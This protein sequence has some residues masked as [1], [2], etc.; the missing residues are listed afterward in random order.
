MHQTFEKSSL[1][2]T[3]KIDDMIELPKSQS[4]RTYKEDLECEMVMVK[5]PKCMSWLDDE[6][7]GDLDMIEDEAENPSPQSSP[8][9]LLSFKECTPPV[10]Y[11]EEA[12][13]T[14]GIPIEIEPLDHTKL[15]DA[16]LNTYSHDLFLSSRE[17]PSFNK[18]EPQPQP[19]PSCPSLDVILGDKRGPEPPIN[20]HSPYSFMMKEVDHLTTHTPP[21]PHVASFHPKDVIEDDFLGEGF[22]LPTGPNELGKGAYAT[23]VEVL[24]L[25]QAYGNLY[26]MTAFGK[27]LED[28]HVTWTQFGKK[29]DKIAALH[30]VVSRICA[31]SLETA[32]QFL[33]T[34]SEPTR[35]GVKIF[36]TM[37]EHNRLNRNPRRFNEAATS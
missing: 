1:A 35:D 30:E 8:Q 36:V 29:R 19:L 31:K 9:V 17:V 11:P 18:S 25:Y 23:V 13:E 22:S 37:S 21:S 14:I 27:L 12:D 7:I 5:M 6:P 34:P 3:G 16:C 24:I 20:P 26:A 32:S 2:M 10:T 4:K 15:E 28:I 33:A